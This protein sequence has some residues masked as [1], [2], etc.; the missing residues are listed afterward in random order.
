VQKGESLIRFFVFA[1]LIPADCAYGL[2]FRNRAKHPSFLNY[3][4]EHTSFYVRGLGVTYDR[5]AQR[6]RKNGRLYCPDS[7]DRDG[8]R[9]APDSD[10]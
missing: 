8:S 3:F 4:Y 10:G 9:K 6:I 2:V 1:L 5:M 7:D